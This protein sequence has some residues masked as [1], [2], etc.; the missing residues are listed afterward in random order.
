MLS[1]R[2]RSIVT[3]TVVLEVGIAGWALGHGMLWL[4]VMTAAVTALDT[5]WGTLRRGTLGDLAGLEIALALS[6]LL[7]FASDTTMAVLVACCCVAWLVR[8]RGPVARAPR[9]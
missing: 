9:H 2:T 5:A 4:L 1:S 6:A 8:D 3:A 7:A